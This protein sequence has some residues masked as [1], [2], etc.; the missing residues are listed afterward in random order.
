[1]V[2]GDDELGVIDFQT[3]CAVVTYDAVSLLRDCYVEWP[4]ELVLE[5]SQQLR[6][7]FR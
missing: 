7:R 1:M 4:D 2:L 5:L 3:L 6:Q